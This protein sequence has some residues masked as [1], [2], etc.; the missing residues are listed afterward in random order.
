MNGYQRIQAALRG[1]QP[2]HPPVMLH[3]FMHAAREAH[4]T[5]AEF[6]Q[7]PRALARSFMQ[8]IEKYALDGVM[9][10]VDTATLAGALGVPVEFPADEPAIARGARLASLADVDALPPPDIARYPVVQV[11][12]E[13]VRLLCAHFGNEVFIRGNCDQCPFALAALVR[14]MEGWLTDIMDPELEPLARGLLDY[15]TEATSHFLRLMSATGAHMLSNGDSAA[16]PSVVSPRIYRRFALPYEQRMAALSHSL[17]VPYALHVC[18]NTKAILAD[19]VTTGADALELDYKTDVRLAHDL[20]KDSTVFIGNLDPSAIVALGTPALVEARSR[21]IIAL[22]GDTRRFILNAGCALPATAPAP[23]APPPRPRPPSA[24]W[25]PLPGR[26][27]WATA[28]SLAPASREAHAACAR[29]P[30]PECDPRADDDR[31]GACPSGW[32]EERRRHRPA[33]AHVRP[34]RGAPGEVCWG[35][36]EG[37][38]VHRYGKAFRCGGRSG[39]RGAEG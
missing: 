11:W 38:E 6:R 32:H 27:E 16:G 3:H 17:G 31:D 23:P 4:V 9:V 37:G 36:G 8:S 19:L 24:P 14:G 34:R 21:R 28:L 12:V 13:A 25:C 26:G 18:G 2:D 15:C 1:E 35:C 7:D 5:M 10:D 22:F 30:G 39:A 33:K 20:M 29:S